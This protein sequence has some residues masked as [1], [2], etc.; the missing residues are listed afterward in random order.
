M[1]KTVTFALVLFAVAY[2]FW[3]ASPGTVSSGAGGTQSAT[4]GAAR[5]IAFTAGQ[6]AADVENIVATMGLRPNW[7]NLGVISMAHS[8]GFSN[9]VLPLFMDD[10]MKGHAAGIFFFGYILLQIPSGYLA[11]NWSA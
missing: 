9:L 6:L 5:V 3:A 7:P 2:P 8:Y 4:T 1:R 10:K 11:S